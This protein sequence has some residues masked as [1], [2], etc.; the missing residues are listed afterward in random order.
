MLFGLTAETAELDK[1]AR[2][3]LYRDEMR[4]LAENE[5]E[6]HEATAFHSLS[7]LGTSHAGRD[8]ATYMRAAA[9]AHGYAWIDAEIRADNTGGLAY[10]QSRGF[11]DYG[12]RTGYRLANG[13]VVDKVL[14]RLDLP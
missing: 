1:E 10:Y 13:Q 11:E 7:I 3:R 8:F 5:P 6:D 2:D 9:V 12:R 4:R 14:K